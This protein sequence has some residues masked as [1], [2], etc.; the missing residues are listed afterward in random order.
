[1]RHA[2]LSQPDGQRA[3][4]SHCSQTIVAIGDLHAGGQACEQCGG[5]EQS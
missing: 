3:L 1:M 4:A 5:R 2:I